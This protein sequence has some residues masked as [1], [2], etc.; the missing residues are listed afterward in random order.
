MIRP[1]VRRV[2]SLE[3][4]NDKL[5]LGVELVPQGKQS[6]DSMISPRRLSRCR[7][8]LALTRR[9]PLPLRIQASAVTGSNETRWVIEHGSSESGA[10]EVKQLSATGETLRRS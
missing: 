2:Q 3:M 8:P 5:L 7:N 6:R 1:R 4:R 9:P 10:A